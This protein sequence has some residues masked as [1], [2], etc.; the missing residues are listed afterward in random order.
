MYAKHTPNYFYLKN[1]YMGPIDI[2]PN[3]E[4]HLKIGVTSIDAKMGGELLEI[5]WSCAGESIYAPVR[6]S[7][8]IQVEGMKKISEENLK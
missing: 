5:I 6:K 3:E 4:I 1:R 8:W 2:Y 7:R